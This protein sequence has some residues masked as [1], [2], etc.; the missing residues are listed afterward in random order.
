MI[1]TLCEVVSR[2]R[3]GVGEKS[4]VSCGGHS[5]SARGVRD[6]KA[7]GHFLHSRDHEHACAI[8]NIWSLSNLTLMTGPA[9]L[10]VHRP[11]RAPRQNNVQGLD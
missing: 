7:R 4:R 1:S 10:R 6:R 11:E 2:Y 3:A 5:V 8:D 9:R